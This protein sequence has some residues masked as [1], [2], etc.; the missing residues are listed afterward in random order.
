MPSADSLDVDILE[1]LLYERG[2]E[3]LRV[4][5]RGA[6]L[7]IVTP[8]DDGPPTKHARLTALPRQEWA[9]DFADHNG[10]WS[11]TPFEGSLQDLV[12]T[13]T[14]KFPWVL[15]IEP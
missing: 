8:S 2:L 10:R 4:T 1:E 5:R 6:R 13:M 7:T 11:P 9:L 15:G 14:E 12:S 3:Q